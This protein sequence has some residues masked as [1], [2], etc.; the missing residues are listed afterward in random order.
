VVVIVSA[1]NQEALRQALMDIEDAAGAGR[2]KWHKSRSERRLR[3]LRLVL[4]ADM[5][6]GCIRA[7]RAGSQEEVKILDAAL[8]LRC[9][10]SLAGLP[11]PKKPL[12]GV[13]SSRLFSLA[14]RPISAKRAGLRRDNPLILKTVEWSVSTAKSGYGINEGSP[15]PQKSTWP[16]TPK[17]YLGTGF[18]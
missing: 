3:Y 4:L 5:W 1:E 6:A 16:Y 10:W 12:T 18:G 11:P 17:P 2:R 7:A 13:F 14:G 9:V 15:A 8:N